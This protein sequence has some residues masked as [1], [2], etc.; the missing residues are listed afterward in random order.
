V[1]SYHHLEQLEAK[2]IKGAADAL[3]EMLSVVIARLAPMLTDTSP[4]AYLGASSQFWHSREEPGVV[5]VSSI[6]YHLVL[7]FSA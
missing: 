4:S 6:F 3:S 7:Q 2:L 1:A 5:G